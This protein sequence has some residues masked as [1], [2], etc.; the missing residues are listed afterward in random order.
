MISQSLMIYCLIAGGIYLIIIGGILELIERKLKLSAQIP[1]ELKEEYGISWFI[2]NWI[3]EFLFFVVIPTLI[4]SFFYIILP[5][6]GLR[7]GMTIALV[8]FTLGAVPFVMGMSM[9]IKL[10]IPFLL[11]SLLGFIIKIGGTISIIG[12]LYSI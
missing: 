5:L 4:F 6:T 11:Y 8:A 9:R 2:I 10:P 7:T 3:L 1:H 12:Y